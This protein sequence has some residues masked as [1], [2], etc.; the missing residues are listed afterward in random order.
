MERY[1]NGCLSTHLIKLVFFNLNNLIYNKINYSINAIEGG[2][3]NKIS[4]IYSK[5]KQDRKRT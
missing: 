3:S 5:F 4:K 2:I 1:L